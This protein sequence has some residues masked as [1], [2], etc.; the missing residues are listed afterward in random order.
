MDGKIEEPQQEWHESRRLEDVQ[1]R[2]Q[3]SRN[4]LLSDLLA[5]QAVKRTS[6]RNEIARPSKGMHSLR[7]YDSA[8]IY[9]LRIFS[10]PT[11]TFF[12]AL[13]VSSTILEC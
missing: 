9:A 4:W 10:R 6:Q 3:I 12:V 13:R 7:S 1:P 11:L 5:Q 2:T 8:A